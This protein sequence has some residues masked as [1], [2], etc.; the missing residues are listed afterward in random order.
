MKTLYKKI[1]RIELK[2]TPINIIP[3]KTN[4]NNTQEIRK[5]VYTLIKG[6]IKQYGKNNIR[7]IIY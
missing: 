6:Y 4:T 5:G 7:A 1:V 2:N 3:I